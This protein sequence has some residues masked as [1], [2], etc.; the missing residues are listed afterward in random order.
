MQVSMPKQP[1][2]EKQQVTAL[3]R[4]VQKRNLELAKYLISEIKVDINAADE[5]GRTPLMHALMEN[6]EPLG[7]KSC[8]C[9]FKTQNFQFTPCLILNLPRME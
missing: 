7:I 8:F 9:Y 6:A 3:I 1:T 2:P 4:T 5:H